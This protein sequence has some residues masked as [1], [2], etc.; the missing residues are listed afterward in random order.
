MLSRVLPPAVL[1]SLG[2]VFASPAA[3][4]RHFSVPTGVYPT[5]QSAVTAAQAAGPGDELNYIELGAS[6]I[7]VS[8]PTAIDGTKFS[9]T[10]QLVIR[11]D[12]SVP[13]LK[14]VAIASYDPGS[15]I[16]DL[17]AGTGEG[18]AVLQDLDIVRAVTNLGDLIHLVGFGH[19]TIERC[20]IGAISTPGP[21]GAACMVITYPYSD[22]VRNCIFFAQ[23]PATF[24]RDLQLTI[25]SDP[26]NSLFLY[27]NVFADY[28]VYGVDLNDGQMGSL[29][30]LR[31]NVLSN[32]P[33]I[34]VLSDPT[35]FASNVALNVVVRSSYNAVM[36]LPGH[37][38]AVSGALAI[39]GANLKTMARTD[40][41]ASFVQSD[42]GPAAAGDAN[43]DFFR[44]I[45]TGALHGSPAT[46]W[47]V[48]VF[49]GSPDAEDI[50]VIDDIERDPRPSGPGT[51]HT[52]RGAD[53]IEVAAAGVE[54]PGIQSL[55]WAAPLGNPASR[56]RIGFRTAEA[57]RLIL[58]AFDLCGRRLMHAE[59]EVSAA[60]NGSFT[61]I[62][63]V[64]PGLVFY[65]VRLVA[66]SGR[67]A[68]SNGRVALLR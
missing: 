57:G 51:G 12:P 58:E 62:V 37:D 59:R 35:A 19:A 41:S 53:Q 67:T 11:P 50:A 14:R 5:I 23:Y 17:V 66:R 55:L 47:G 30:V 48:N 2:V 15:L 6:P 29:L 38:E 46:D 18:H 31:N 49:N 25:C 39:E 33:G 64:R 45:A 16:F 42:W 68:E 52:D 54:P 34:A 27:N 3:A 44:L 13:G 22:V 4:I 28:G 32:N 56:L 40:L 21:A 26:A 8:G 65:R 7:N 10:R 43:P 60:A 20:R 61:E 9:P 1:F 36:I 24:S 63:P